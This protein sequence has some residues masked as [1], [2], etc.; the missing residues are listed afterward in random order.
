MSASDFCPH[1]SS[2]SA[3]T[4]T[5]DSESSPPHFNTYTVP[6]AQPV[7]ERYD[8]YRHFNHFAVNHSTDYAPQPDHPSMQL[9]ISY[10]ENHHQAFDY[11]SSYSGTN[12]HQ[13]A[14]PP[15]PRRPAF[16][17]I[18]A[19]PEMT[20]FGGA[21]H[22]PGPPSQP[23]MREAPN[24]FHP[25]L[26]GV[27]MNYGSMPPVWPSAQEQGYG[28][29]NQQ[30]QAQYPLGPGSEATRTR[31]TADHSRQSQ[32]V[33]RRSSQQGV[34]HHHGS[35]NRWSLD[36]AERRAFRSLHGQ[37]RLPDDP[38]PATA[39]RT[40][41]S[42]IQDMSR[43]INSSE[44]EEAAPRL[45]PSFRTRRL[46]R[47]HRMRHSIHSQPH[48][49]NLANS[50][51]IQALKDKLPRRLLGQLPEGTSPT[52]DI[53]AKDYSSTSVQACEE[54]EI[55]IELPCGHYFGE[56]CIFEWVC[57]GLIS[58]YSSKVLLTDV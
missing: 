28:A 10:E 21:G 46:P 1:W 44:A 43:S 51:Q 35:G 12:P 13:A 29:L 3:S 5:Q 20:W 55:A 47:E 32:P 15:V 37:G 48:D 31:P 4:V 53:C 56:F 8:P 50:R 41:D 27:E 23:M 49:P 38:P 16:S 54:A 2:T 42:F 7:G 58:C 33:A 9:P 17:P 25:Y 57:I 36:S 19:H 6:F 26:H 45:P 24:S 34:R 39:R 22:M 30:M 52:C 11:R 14:Q 18:D 40:Y